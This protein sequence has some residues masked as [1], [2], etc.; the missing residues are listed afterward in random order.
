MLMRVRVPALRERL[1]DIR[2]VAE[3]LLRNASP[4]DT[5]R[6]SQALI[7]RFCNYEWHRNITELRSVLRRLLLQPHGGL[8]DVCHLDDL[9]SSD[10]SCFGFLPASV[11]PIPSPNSSSFLVHSLSP[12]SRSLQ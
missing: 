4:F 10:E 2:A 1:E 3:A 11:R 8:L 5:I 6:C 7:D 12:Q 9:I